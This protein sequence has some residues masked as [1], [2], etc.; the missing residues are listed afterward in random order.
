MHQIV[1]EQDHTM[2]QPLP[3][4]P[5]PTLLPPLTI[6]FLNSGSVANFSRI[7][8][9]LAEGVANF[10]DGVADHPRSVV[11]YPGSVANF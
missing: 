1:S 10:S 9:N 4:T 7:V 5:S 6:M 2:L 8:A 3:M 11:N